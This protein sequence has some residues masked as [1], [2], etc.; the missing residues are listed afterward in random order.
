MF[1]NNANSSS[2]GQANRFESL[3]PNE[4]SD[5]ANNENSCDDFKLNELI[6]S[7]PFKSIIDKCNRLGFGMEYVKPVFQKMYPNI[8]ASDENLIIDRVIEYAME[9]TLDVDGTDLAEADQ[10]P[11]AAYS[12]RPD[13][14]TKNESLFEVPNYSASNPQQL[15]PIDQLNTGLK[16]MNVIRH[17]QKHS[18]SSIEAIAKTGS[19]LRP[20]IIDGDNLSYWYAIIQH[21]YLYLIEN[22]RVLK[23]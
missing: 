22:V 5:T 3:D 19:N 17:H 23:S 8:D 18:Q 9:K 13:A 4:N 7:S 16:S 12:A 1:A 15:R 10:F 20:I 6:I 11:N 2:I 14:N 21:F